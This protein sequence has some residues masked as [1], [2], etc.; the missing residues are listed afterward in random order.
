MGWKTVVPVAAVYAL[1][2]APRSAWLTPVVAG[3]GSVPAKRGHLRRTRHDQGTNRLVDPSLESKPRHRGHSPASTR[4]PRRR[5]RPPRRG[6]RGGRCDRLSGDRA[7]HPRGRPPGTLRPIPGH[8]FRL[9]AGVQVITDVPIPP[10]YLSGLLGGDVQLQDARLD[11]YYRRIASVHSGS[12]FRWD[13]LEDILWLHL[14]EPMFPSAASFLRDGPD[15][16]VWFD[17][18]GARRLSRSI[19]AHVLRPKPDGYPTTG[20]EV[21]PVHQRT[22]WLSPDDAICVIFT[23][24][25]A[26]TSITIGASG[27]MDWSLW[28]LDQAYNTVEQHSFHTQGPPSALRRST[29][30]VETE[31]KLGGVCVRKTAGEAG[32]WLGFVTLGTELP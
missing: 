32:G 18:K 4:H 29:I 10:G 3:W 5:T 25:Q 17:E 14:Y 30:P 20:S 13:R 11:E 16:L 8:A 1:L 24:P 12:L 15:K 28:A 2:V 9:W 22:Q 26:T 23:T 7:R 27:G 21:L 19:D 6:G 31:G